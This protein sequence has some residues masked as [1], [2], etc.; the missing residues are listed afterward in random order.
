MEVLAL[1]VSG[2]GSP[3]LGADTARLDRLLEQAIGAFGDL[4]VTLVVERSRELAERPHNGRH[5][6][7]AGMAHLQQPEGPATVAGVISAA[8]AVD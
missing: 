1:A 5:R 2:S 7:L 3:E 8:L 6:V 4:D